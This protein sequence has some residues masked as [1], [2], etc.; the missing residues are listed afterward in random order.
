MEPSVTIKTTQA[1]I[2]IQVVLKTFPRNQACL[3]V[4]TGKSSKCVRKP[5]WMEGKGNVTGMNCNVAA[6]S[7]AIKYPWH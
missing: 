3:I 2:S 7:F 4:A 5:E 1:L 6:C